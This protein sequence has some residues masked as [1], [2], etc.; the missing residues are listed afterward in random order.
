[1]ITNIRGRWT[2]RILFHF[3]HFQTMV[4][5][6][7]SDLISFADSSILQTCEPQIHKGTRDLPNYGIRSLRTGVQCGTKLV[8]DPSLL[9]MRPHGL[10][11]RVLVRK[12]QVY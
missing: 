5:A 11:R 7:L 3:L 4:V 12:E 2:V 8:M 1:V 10:D 6:L 9:H